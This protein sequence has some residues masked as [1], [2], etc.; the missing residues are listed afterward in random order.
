[1][2][3]II[4]D[5]PQLYIAH[6]GDDIVHTGEVGALQNIS[7]GQPYLETFD[8]DQREQYEARLTE[9][10]VSPEELVDPMGFPV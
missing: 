9:L 3:H 10:G 7:T 8:I 2:H 1:M 4:T 5:K 6:N